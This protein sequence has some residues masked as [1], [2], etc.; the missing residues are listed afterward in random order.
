MQWFRRLKILPVMMFVVLAALFLRVN[1]FE[2]NA[3]RGLIITTAIVQADDT[4]KDDSKKGDSKKDAPADAK[5]DDKKSDDKKPDDKSDGKTDDKNAKPMDDKSKDDKSKDQK[6]MD[7][8]NHDPLDPVI[9]H[10]G[11]PSSELVVLQDLSER[12]KQQDKREVDLVQREALLQASEKRFQEKMNELTALRDEIKK[13]VDAA[14]A[15]TNADTQRLVD[16]YEKMKPKDA[17]GIFDTTSM[18]VLLP[19]VTAMKETKLS[20]I[21]ASMSPDKA[22]AITAALAQKAKVLPSDAPARAT[23]EPTSASLP[24]SAPAGPPAPQ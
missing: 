17:A 10:E 6:K 13:L 1:S 18:D 8:S 11:R 3:Q 19:I 16:I 5:P 24:Q 2:H 20:P 22:K 9:G 15:K 12:R 21:M 23:A 7:E 14:N 4:K